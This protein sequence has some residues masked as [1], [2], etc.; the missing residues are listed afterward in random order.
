MFIDPS[1]WTLNDLLTAPFPF[2]PD[3]DLGERH[4]KEE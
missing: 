3:G 2:V 4:G 1:I